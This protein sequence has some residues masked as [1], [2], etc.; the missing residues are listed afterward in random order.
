MIRKFIFG[1]RLSDLGE[2]GVF[3]GLDKKFRIWPLSGNLR[4][5]AG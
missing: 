4:T 2:I 1:M 3:W 5:R